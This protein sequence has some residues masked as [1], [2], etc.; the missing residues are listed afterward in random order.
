MTPAEIILDHLPA[1]REAFS[2]APGALGA[3][4]R[5]QS[6]CPDLT[7]AMT[8]SA[9]KAVAPLVLLTAEQLP[10]DGATSE[11]MPSATPA[12]FMDW[13]VH[14]NKKGYIRLHKRVGGRVW[15]VYIG[16]TW[17]AAKARE[18]IEA[19]TVGVPV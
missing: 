19:L 8:F 14:T 12:S 16:K 18:R 6:T 17:D 9:F 2:Q 11:P 13:S 1:V 5:L 4:G 7:A 3:W 10:N 15:S